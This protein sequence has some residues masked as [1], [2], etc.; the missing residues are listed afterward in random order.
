M[1]IKNG[2]NLTARFWTRTRV[3]HF[4]FNAYTG[5]AFYIQRV[6]GCL[7]L[8]K[9]AF[10]DNPKGVSFLRIIL[11]FRPFQPL[12]LRELRHSCRCTAE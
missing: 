1:S 12:P 5:G 4:I 10:R 9:N 2:N 11:H 3:A 6:P 7:I 8:D